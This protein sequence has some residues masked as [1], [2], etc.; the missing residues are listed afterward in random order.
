MTVR[1]EM[2]KFVPIFTRFNEIMVSSKL[3][4]ILVTG[5]M[6]TWSMR[7]SN[8]QWKNAYHGD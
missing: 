6:H 3:N 1:K 4:L 7:L 8:K 2:F 5:W